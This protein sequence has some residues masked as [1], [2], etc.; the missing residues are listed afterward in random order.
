M[1][2]QVGPHDD[3][4]LRGLLDA[5]LVGLYA[6]AESLLVLPSP[7]P[8]VR[9]NERAV[10][11]RLAIHVDR[12]LQRQD[13]DL[14]VDVEYCRSGPSINA[15]TWTPP[16]A[17][18]P[19]L[20][21]PDLIVHRRGDPDANLLAVEVKRGIPGADEASFDEQKMQAL[22]QDRWSGPDDVYQQSAYR[23]GLCLQLEQDQAR[24]YWFADGAGESMVPWHSTAAQ[25]PP[26]EPGSCGCP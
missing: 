3:S 26:S 24:L 23:L 10:A 1:T 4:W 11:A 12:E 2:H 6:E 7:G 22:T 19:T 16:A 21:Y 17:S 14:T 25:A 8:G 20:I 15:K 18:D 9:A 5:G 13:C